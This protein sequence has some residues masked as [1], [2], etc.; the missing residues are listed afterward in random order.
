ML[1]TGVAPIRATG[2]YRHVPQRRDRQLHGDRCSRRIVRR[3][4][5][6][7]LDRIR[8]E[9]IRRDGIRAHRRAPVRD[10]APRILRDAR[11]RAEG[12]ADG[13]RGIRPA[14]R[15]FVGGSC[16]LL[17]AARP[18]CTASH[19]CSP[20]TAA[21]NSSAATHDTPGNTSSRFTRRSR[22][23]CARA[24]WS[25][26]CIPAWRRACRCCARREAMSTRRA[27]RC[28]RGMKP[29][30]CW[31]GSAPPTSSIPAFSKGSTRRGRLR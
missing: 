23:C 8:R 28:L 9:R 22:R 12:A 21:T 7:V 30:T 27:C 25:R 15:Q 17:C 3:T 24:C 5:P 13:R 19:A 11:R 18:R 14:I 16:L 20:A 1:R 4:R 26:C 31:S 6:H 2:P 29:T 10:D